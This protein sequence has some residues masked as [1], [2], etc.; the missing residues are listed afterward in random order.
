MLFKYFRKLEL[1]VISHRLRDCRYGNIV[2]QQLLR[3]YYAMIY[4]IALRRLPCVLDEYIAQIRAAYMQVVGNFLDMRH[5]VIEVVYVI[6]R[7]CNIRFLRRDRRSAAVRMNRRKQHINHALPVQLVIGNVQRGGVIFF[8]QPVQNLVGIKIKAPVIVKEIE[9]QKC[10][11]RVFKIHPC[12]CPG[13]CA[14]RYSS[15]SF[16]PQL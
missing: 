3:A 11:L 8:D 15:K 2:L 14:V 1:I 5:F 6:D 12:I 16:R 4:K 9:I 7:A 10:V 13:V